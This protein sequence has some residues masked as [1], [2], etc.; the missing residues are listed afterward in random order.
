[1]SSVRRLARVVPVALVLLAGCGGGGGGGGPT[2]QV[3]RIFVGNENTN[4]IKAFDPAGAVT[5]FFT[6]PPFGATPFVM[7]GL[8]F[9]D[10]AD[11]LYSARAAVGP[12][13]SDG[14]VYAYDAAGNRTLFS[15]TRPGGAPLNAYGL[16]MSSTGVLHA[17]LLGPS[18]IVSFDGAGTATLVH[19][20]GVSASTFGLA[21]GPSG[22]W[23]FSNLDANTVSEVVA[24][25]PTTYAD[26]TDGLNGPAGIAFDASGRLYV[27]SV[28]GNVVHRFTAPHTG[29]VF[30]D[31]ADGVSSPMGIAVDV[32]GD[33]WLTGILGAD[34]LLRFDSA[35][36]PVGVPPF[37]DGTDGLSA[38]KS[39]ALK[40]IH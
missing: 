6:G 37:A 12:M 39:V 23:F 40:Q 28:N 26:A 30:V 5:P 7:T 14:N 19:D 36:A 18:Q 31:A 21:Q 1:M 24:G 2:P 9:D 29:S 15:S 13:V 10:A 38:P 11:R 3:V 34:T 27:A 33:V 17:L 20:L 25:V 32:T 8:A 22:T 4:S 35:G 16:A